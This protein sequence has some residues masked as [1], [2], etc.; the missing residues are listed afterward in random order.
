[1]TIADEKLLIKTLQGIE[2]QLESIAWQ[3]VYGNNSDKKV[4]TNYLNKY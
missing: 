2:K 1:M 4:P 3:M